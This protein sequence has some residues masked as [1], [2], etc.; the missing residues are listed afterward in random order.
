[1]LEGRPRVA[2]VDTG[3]PD[4]W[5]YALRGPAGA[6]WVAWYEPP[7][8]AGPGQ[9]APARVVRVPVG[10]R[11]LASALAGPRLAPPQGRQVRSAGAVHGDP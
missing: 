5:V 3:S 11:R 4:V 6:A 9:I 7:D 10:A 2:R 1:M 8:F